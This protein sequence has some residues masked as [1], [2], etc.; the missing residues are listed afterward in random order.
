MSLTSWYCPQSW[1][2]LLPVVAQAQALF[3]PVVVAFAAWVLLLPALRVLLP[4][5]LRVLLQV[6]HALGVVYEP[7]LASSGGPRL[8]RVL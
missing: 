1:V 8:R 5:A 4:P 7:P 3:L 6:A 2:L